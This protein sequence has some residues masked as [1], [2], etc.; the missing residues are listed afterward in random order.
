MELLDD[1]LL[2]RSDV[3]ANCCMNRERSLTGSNG[4]AKE[5]GFDPLRR[6]QEKAATDGQASWLDLCCG[7]GRALI[8]AAQL[9]S[10]AGLNTRI[11]IVGVD[12]VGMFLPEAVDLKRVSLVRASLTNWQ[13]DRR[14]DV[15][16]CVHGLHYI[17]DKLG[18]IARAVSWLTADGHFAANLDLSNLKHEDGR[19]ASRIV[20]SELRR[21]G[22]GYDRRTKL[23]SCDGQRLVNFPFRYLGADDHA[24][25]NY[26]KQAV[27][28]SYYARA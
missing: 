18:L 11:E 24:G 10:A 8:E 7:S 5:L 15:I 25:P 9:A 22:L 26:T 6:L 4:Y 1:D 27:V 12:L 14:F 21:N 20:A 3:V 17:G 13:P 2:E 28:D 16:T 19:S 23:V